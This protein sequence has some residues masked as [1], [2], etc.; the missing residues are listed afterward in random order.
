MSASPSLSRMI[1][2]SRCVSR[3]ISK[4]PKQPRG[5]VKQ[6]PSAAAFR[7]TQPSCLCSGKP[8]CKATAALKSMSAPVGQRARFSL[9]ISQKISSGIRSSES[10]CRVA[11]GEE[12]AFIRDLRIYTI[13][14]RECHLECGTRLHGG[15]QPASIKQV[16]AVEQKLRLPWP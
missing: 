10:G 12:G 13:E 4:V 7:I 9:R 1:I 2:K 5:C 8:L 3:C 11:S 16:F 14:V 15:E 6:R